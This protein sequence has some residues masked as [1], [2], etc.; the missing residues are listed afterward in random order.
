MTYL[1]NRAWSDRFIPTIR[2][3]VGPHLLTPAPL[4]VDANE[5]TDL[6]V[7]SARDMRIAARIRRCG[8][9]TKYANEFTIRS[10]LANGHK[11]ELAKLV[12]G[13]G[14][15]MF[16]GHAAD[17]STTNLARWMLI[18]LHAWRAGLIRDRYKHK[19]RCDEK[20]NRDGTYFVFFDACSFP[21]DPPLLVA[22]SHPDELRAALAFA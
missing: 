7:L 3:I 8:Y 12:D 15:W 5:A 20:D 14:D 4:D 9:A 13:F 6:I 21:D 10:R 16:Y 17:D 2:S 19:I 22:C 1:I 18:D 11:T